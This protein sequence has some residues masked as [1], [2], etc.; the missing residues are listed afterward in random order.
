[1]DC[2]ICGDEE[3]EFR[4]SIEG[5]V[6]SSCHGCSKMGTVLE[7]LRKAEPTVRGNEPGRGPKELAYAS[8]AQEEPEIVED[9]GERIRRAM[10]RLKLT[11][12][13]VAERTNEKESYIRRIENGETEPG[14]AIAR[15]LEDELDILLFE[16]REG[17]QAAPGSR[18]KELTM[19]D[20]IGFEIGKGNGKKKTGKKQ[21]V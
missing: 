12:A 21:E 1:M 10:G 4:I 19:A 18:S 9:Y 16:I 15:K 13:V 3:A 5:A 7:S 20:L 11:A 17:G 14:E 8:A 2:E 6:L